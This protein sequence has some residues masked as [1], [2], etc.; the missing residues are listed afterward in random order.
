MTSTTFVILLLY[1][2][3]PFNKRIKSRNLL[4]YISRLDRHWL[5]TLRYRLGVY[6]RYF[7]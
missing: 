1:L 4:F 2:H 5:L 6:S 3:I 7:I